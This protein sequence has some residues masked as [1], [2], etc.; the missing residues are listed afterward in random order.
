MAFVRRNTTH[1]LKVEGLRRVTAE[2]V[3][4]EALREA[5]VNAVAHRNYE[6]AG[7]KIAVEVFSDRAV[8]SSPGLPPGNQR[9]EGIGQGEGR[10]RA[11]NPLVDQGLTWLELMDERGSGIRR[12]REV[13]RRQGRGMPKFA[14]VEDEFAVTLERKKI[15]AVLREEAPHEEPGEDLL[16]SEPITDRQK[17]IL[18]LMLWSGNQGQDPE[19]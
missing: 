10:S 3:P 18:Q 13:M 19:M 6:N 11:R 8:F 16:G 7:V 1:P 17:Q 5:V 9:N 12:M 4:Q 2:D 14:L 15:Q